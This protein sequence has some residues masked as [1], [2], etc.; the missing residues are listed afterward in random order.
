MTVFTRIFSVLLALALATPTLARQSTD[1]DAAPPAAVPPTISSVPVPASSAPAQPGMTESE[2]YMLGPED[3]IEVNVLGQ[4]DFKTQARVEA[5]GS[6]AL[7]FIGKQQVSGQTP[8]SLAEAISARLKAGGYFQNPVA[9]VTV[10]SYASRYVI[11]LGEVAQPG[12]Q[13]VNRSYRVSEIIARAGGIKPSGAAHIILRRADGQEQKLAFKGL[14][15]GAESE[16]PVVFPGD[17]VFVPEAE[18]FYIYGQVNA[19][20]TFPLQE[21]MTVRKALARAGGLT[22]I[23]SQKRVKVYRDGEATKV[24]LET[25][26]RPGDVIVVGERLF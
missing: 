6:I 1:G 13:P 25:R 7:P 14:A 12:L 5:D 21:D 2:G 26:V 3:V 24:P 10:V 20:G 17:K 4:P 15:M 16:D 9:A 23:G 22:P 19:P 18:T 8:L 11:V